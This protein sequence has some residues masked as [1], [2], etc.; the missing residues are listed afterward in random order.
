MLADKI[1]QIMAEKN[2]SSSLFADEICI[3]RAS[4]SHILAVRHKPSLIIVRKIIK[5]FPDVGM[6]WI[7]EEDDEE[8]ESTPTE[9]V[10]E[11][12]LSEPVYQKTTAGKRIERIVIFY[13]DRTFSEY[14]P[15]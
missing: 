11:T 1:K 12:G 9:A 3:T 4:I 2:L 5:R 14:K 13:S 15:S 8:E 7:M 6:D 10:P